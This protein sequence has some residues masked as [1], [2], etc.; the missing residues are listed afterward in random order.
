V[1]LKAA[2]IELG[3]S[4]LLPGL[5]KSPYPTL[6]KGHAMN[7][8]PFE[9]WLLSEEV[10]E[11]DQEHALREHLRHCERCASLEASWSDVHQLI[12]TAPHVGPAAGFVARWEDRLALERKK[13]HARQSWVFL[14]LTAG[15]AVILF[16]LL[17]I[18]TAELL[19]F[20]EQLILLTIYRLA[21]LI[22]YIFATQN[23]VFSLFGTVLEL[24]PAPVWIGLFGTFT[25]VC[26]LWFVM[27]KQLL[28]TRRI[29]L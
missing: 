29:S 27:F 19:R 6:L 18:Q 4:W 5:N 20:P 7:H 22:G 28:Y 2:C 14:A 26:V 16:L 15:A 17:G 21:T 23:L 3:A 1:R 13:R 24:V 8:Q 12:D 11:Q 25:M 9:S 10:L